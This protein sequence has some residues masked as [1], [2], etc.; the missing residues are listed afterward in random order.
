MGRG[1]PGGALGPALLASAHEGWT[2]R[3]WASETLHPHW[4]RVAATPALPHLLPC[5]SLRGEPVPRVWQGKQA[6][7]RP[8]P[9][10]L[11]QV[12]SLSGF[13]IS[14][15]PGAAACS[16]AQPP[17]TRNWIPGRGSV[18]KGAGEGARGRRL[19][20]TRRRQAVGTH[21]GPGPG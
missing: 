19:G 10:S 12:S 13:L 5:P 16:L 18:G 17:P 3:A 21:R 9:A 2:W 20:G 14:P 4:M 7:A 15:A 1:K 11:A 6:P 8:A